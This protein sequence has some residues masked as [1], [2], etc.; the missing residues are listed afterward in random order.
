MVFQSTVTLYRY[1]SHAAKMVLT[2]IFVFIKITVNRTYCTIESVKRYSKVWGLRN[3]EIE[4]E[5]QIF[6]PISLSYIEID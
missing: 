4:T 5:I 1:V 6:A 3:R 2:S